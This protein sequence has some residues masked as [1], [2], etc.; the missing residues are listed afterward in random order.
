M[1][2][3]IRQTDLYARMAG[4]QLASVSVSEDRDIVT[5]DFEDGWRV[6]YC[7]QA[8]CCSTSWIEHLELPPNLAGSELVGVIEGGEV[9][10]WDGHLCGTCKHDHL[11]VYNTR[12]VTDRGETLT[13][14]YRNDSNG[15]YGGWLE[16]SDEG[17]TV[18]EKEGTE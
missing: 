18:N 15:Y 10:P 16:L 6:R 17:Q 3:D 4:R 14:E 7:A 13:I 5:F 12:F 9:A 2:P 1:S 8:G 11:E